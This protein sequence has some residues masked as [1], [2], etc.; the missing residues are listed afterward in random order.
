MSF[1]PRSLNEKGFAVKGKVHCSATPDGKQSNNDGKYIIPF[2]FV[3]LPSKD[4]SKTKI[5]RRYRLI[6]CEQAKAS[7]YPRREFSKA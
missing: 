5:I 3:P 1:F 4:K 6:G 2:P 7:E